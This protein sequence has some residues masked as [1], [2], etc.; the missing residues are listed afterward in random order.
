MGLGA[1][2]FGFLAGLLSTLSPCVLPLLP[3]ALGG[4]MAGHRLGAVMLASGLVVSFVAMGL[5]VAVAGFAIGLDEDRL[6]A[7]SAVLLAGFGLLLLSEAL[8]GRV[9][10]ATGP[11]ADAGNRLIARLSP[12]GLPGQFV[13]GLLLGVAWSPC[14][15]PTLGAA[16]VLAANARDLGV[17]A[18]VMAAFACGA[19]VPLLLVGT[20]SRGLLQRWRGPIRRAG[21]TGRGLLG[22]AMLTIA[23]LILSGQERALE[24]GLVNA[25]PDWLIDLTT[26]F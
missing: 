14:V 4:A 17:V 26:R 1:A 23:V 11:V 16:S 21:R 19:A 8:R 6:R 3:L 20:V 9:V 13:L 12:T 22:G 2:G 25:S 10:V 15:G 18:V 24:T 5:V 7:L